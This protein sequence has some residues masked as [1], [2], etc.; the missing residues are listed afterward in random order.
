V[1]WLIPE[2]TV[3][4]KPARWNAG[5]ENHSP[6]RNIFDFPLPTPILDNYAGRSASTPT[7]GN[8]ADRRTLPRMR[9]TASAELHPEEKGAAPMMAGIA[10]LSMGGCF[11][12]MPMPLPIGT[13]LKVVVWLDAVKLQ[14]SA[15]VS[16][17]RPG[18][19][20]GLQFTGLPPEEKSKLEAY[21]A[22]IPRYPFQNPR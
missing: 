18:F 9:C 3:S 5:L 4:G 12:D 11:V 16:N 10:D 20:I 8:A 14:T 7:G 2:A 21:L 19:G 15:V 6:E 22:K 13:R 17:T 1:K